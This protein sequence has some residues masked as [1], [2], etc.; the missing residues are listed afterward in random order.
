MDLEG[1]QN[2]MER[3]RKECR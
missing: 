2:Q 3:N 1:I